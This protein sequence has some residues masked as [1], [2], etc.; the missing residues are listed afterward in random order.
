M[1]LTSWWVLLKTRRN[2]FGNIAVGLLLFTLGW[3]LGRVMSP[4]YA[5]H[6]IIFTDRSTPASSGGTI[7]ELV[8]LQQEGVADRVAKKSPV[9]A[10]TRRQTTDTQP[11]GEERAA[12]FVGSVNSDKYHHLDCSTWGRIN[13]ANRIWFDSVE[14]AEAAG[15][16]PTICT[17]GKLGLP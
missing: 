11:V 14:Q 1:D 15:Y 9:V 17:K 2:L 12:Q 6:P 16:Q 3:Q 13:E 4:Y 10:A 5:A 7:D 8:T